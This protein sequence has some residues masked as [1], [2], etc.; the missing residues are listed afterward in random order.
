MDN[1]SLHSVNRTQFAF[2]SEQTKKKFVIRIRQEIYIYCT[3]TGNHHS[4]VRSTLVRYFH[5]FLHF[6]YCHRQ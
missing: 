1:T 3:A 5:K 6:D 2:L 4:I